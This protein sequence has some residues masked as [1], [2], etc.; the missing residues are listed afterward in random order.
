MPIAL[1]ALAIGAF[2]LG[3]TETIVMGLLPQLSAGLGVSIAQAGLLVSGYALGVTIASP[4]VAVLTN[5]YSRRY[6][7][8]LTMAIFTVGNALSAI[9]PGYWS[10]MVARVVTSLSHGTF[11]GA[12]SVMA[13]QVVPPHQRAKAL[14]LV[15]IGLTLAMILGV[16]LGTVVAQV[17]SWRV[18]FGLIA[19]IG[20]VAWLSIRVWVPQ[21]KVSGPPVKLYAQLHAMTRPLVVTMM[22]VSMCTSASMFSL[23][24]Y[25]TP[26]LQVRTGF[27][28]HAVDLV[29]LLIGGGLCLGNLLGGRLADWKMLPSC[30]GL[31]LAV[32]VVQLLLVPGSLHVWTCLI[33]LFLWG[34]FIY[35]PM[36]PLQSYVVTCSGS[37]PNIASA[38]NQSS[39][40][41]GN[42][43]GAWAGSL[44]VA[45]PES[46]GGLP[47]LSAAM[48]GLGCALVFLAK[49]F[50]KKTQQAGA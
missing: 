2:G 8:L 17:S 19:A 21:D 38:M 26:F 47:Y 48:A 40:N 30:A 6:T 37:A 25:I 35:A 28:E 31:M 22:L 9:A 33:L 46:Y 34:V 44:L 29:L 27:S 1:I 36:A 10:L 24:T 39:F 12:A 49:Y 15:Y 16:P 20:V 32:A 3:T 43:V 18:A 45:G 5:A 7:L 50:E 42:A 4:V 23:F 14:S 13:C 11:Y 41:F